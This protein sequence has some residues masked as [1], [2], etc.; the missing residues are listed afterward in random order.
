[1]NMLVFGQGCIKK[2][3]SRLFIAAFI[4]FMW[5]PAFSA[6]IWRNISLE[7]LER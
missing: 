7:M 6:Y 4:E 3:L 1:M 2:F 5:I